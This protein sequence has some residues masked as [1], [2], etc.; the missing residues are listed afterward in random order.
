MKSR[1]VMII[2]LL[3]VLTSTFA[4][5]GGNKKK[6]SNPPDSLLPWVEG[7]YSCEVVETENTCSGDGP[8]EFPDPIPVT[9]TQVD[10]GT[11]ADGDPIPTDE[12]YFNG[13]G[14]NFG[15]PATLTTAGTFG[16][17]DYVLSDVMTVDYTSVFQV[18]GD[19]IAEGNDGAMRIDY[20]QG[21]CYEG[22]S[23]YN[24]LELSCEKESDETGGG[25]GESAV[26]PEIRYLFDARPKR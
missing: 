2:G 10:M 26:A 25:G 8:R 15:G 14:V 1:A 22:N 5:G 16:V 13:G 11:D 12:V 20:A 7:S 23:G 9:F 21:A 4:C 19:G 18:D 17:V 3:F 24:V 6:K